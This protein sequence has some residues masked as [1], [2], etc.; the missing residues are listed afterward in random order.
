MLA[1]SAFSC[2]VARAE[3]RRLPASLW[4]ELG[5]ESNQ[6]GLISIMAIFIQCLPSEVAPGN[7]HFLTDSNKDLINRQ[8][9]HQDFRIF[10]ALQS[11]HDGS[12][13]A[14]GW[15]TVGSE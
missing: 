3:I 6:Y 15:H 9:R 1:E 5:H 8:V 4:T 11:T 12:V 2:H 14:V 10:A 13:F 7:I